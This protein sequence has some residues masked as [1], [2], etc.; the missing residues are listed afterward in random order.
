[1]AHGLSTKFEKAEFTILG[2][3][4]VIMF[5]M[6]PMIGNELMMPP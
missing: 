1:M 2:L 4:C 6:P 3:G 5:L